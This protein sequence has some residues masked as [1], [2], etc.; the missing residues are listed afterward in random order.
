MLF[1]SWGDTANLR[2]R[3]VRTNPRK[4]LDECNYTCTVLKLTREGFVKQR[5]LI[6]AGTRK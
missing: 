2:N 4:A 5:S 1:Y 3:E 6:T